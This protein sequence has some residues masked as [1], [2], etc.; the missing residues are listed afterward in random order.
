MNAKTPY[1]P[2]ADGWTD[3]VWH[4][5]GLPALVGPFWQK[6]VDGRR[7]H[8]LLVEEKHSNI[9]GIVH[10]GMISTFLDQTLGNTVWEAVDRGPNVT[11]QLNVHFNLHFIS[12]AKQG[13]FLVAEGE[14]MRVTRPIVLALGRLTAGDRLIAY[15]DGVWK[16]LGAGLYYPQ[17]P[18]NSS[19]RTYSGYTAS[20]QNS[21]HK[22][23]SEKLREQ[24][25]AW[26]FIFFP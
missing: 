3:F 20:S 25:T 21:K 1:D 26:S 18:F 10:G 12:G 5:D 23:I 17:Y 7:L 24:L 13:D 22:F 14:V 9:H 15:A 4:E 8:G 16:R 19:F 2:A 11:M 6:T